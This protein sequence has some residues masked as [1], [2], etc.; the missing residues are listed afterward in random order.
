MRVCVRGQC[1]WALC[2]HG[3]QKKTFKINEK[4]EDV[5]LNEKYG[6]KKWSLNFHDQP[7]LKILHWSVCR[8]NRGKVNI[9]TEVLKT[10]DENISAIEMF[11]SFYSE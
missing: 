10:K 7:N 3:R 5:G 11:S 2:G 8:K 1:A 9:Q 6:N 4:I